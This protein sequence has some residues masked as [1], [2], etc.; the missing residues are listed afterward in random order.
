M[1]LAT[2]A[3]MREI[4]RLAAQRGYSYA[5]MMERAGTAVAEWIWEEC[6]D[7]LPSR[8][9]TVVCGR[10]NNGGDGYVIARLLSTRAHVTV[11]RADGAASTELAVQNERA[12]PQTVTVLDYREEPYLCGAAVKEAALLID[13]VYGVGFHGEI[14]VQIA[15]LV[16]Q[17]NNATAYKIAVDMPSGVPADGTAPAADAFR[18]DVTLTFTARKEGQNSVHSGAVR[19]LD[20]AVPTDIV[21]QVLGQNAITEE[22]VRSC[23]SPRPLGTRQ[24]KL[25]WYFS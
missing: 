15:P 24:L 20:I 2:T 21:E 4:E 16:K 11:I 18:A 7:K 3:D 23:I 6:Y 10:G 9:V 22:L 14:S 25:F 19:V 1:K 17:M 8:S 12:L 5:A 13:C